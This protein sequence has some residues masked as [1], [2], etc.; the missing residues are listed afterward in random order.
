M[1]SAWAFSLSRVSVLL[2][3]LAAPSHAEVPAGPA[4]AP[5]EGYAGDRY[6]DS[7]GC[8]YMRAS[9]GGALVWVPHLDANRKPVC[10]L[11]P[12]FPPPP[13]VRLVEVQAVS[14]P[15]ASCPAGTKQAQRFVLSDGRTILHCGEAVED[16]VAFLN[17]A[18]LPGIVVVPE[19]PLP[20]SADAAGKPP[21][22][23]AGAE[24]SPPE[25]RPHT[26]PLPAPAAEPETPDAPEP[27]TEPNPPAA[28]EPTAVPETP[29]PP[30]VPATSETGAYVQVGAFGKP[31]NARRVETQLKDMGLPVTVLEGGLTTVLAGPFT[32][33]AAVREALKTLRASGFPEAFVR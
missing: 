18:K 22:E 4:E 24:A 31:E 7:A 15:P 26:A 20:G 5:P 12:T 6:V 23:Q 19:E 9:Q 28:P 27:E 8:A 13:P 30:D 17:A 14:E 11:P 32:D 3:A 2:V 21:V 10:G 1:R 29:Q 33:P 25:L 16:P